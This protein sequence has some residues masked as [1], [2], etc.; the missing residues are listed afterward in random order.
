MQPDRGPH[1]GQPSRTAD[2]AGVCDLTFQI[3][4]LDE[5]D[6]VP[7][8]AQANV[9]AVLG[10]DR[11][12]VSRARNEGQR[13]S[14]G[15]EHVPHL[16]AL[17]P[18]DSGCRLLMAWLGHL[19]ISVSPRSLGE[20]HGDALAHCLD[21]SEA[22]GALSGGLRRATRPDSDGGRDIT[23]CEATSLLASAEAALHAAAAEVETLRRAAKAG[24]R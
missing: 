17:F 21:A 22:V 12:Q 24:R 8:I 3:A 2:T 13:L 15:I 14:I 19:H 4:L 16:L 5:L 10:V 6:R 11:S 7:G 1:K 20:S 9:A 18:V 23:P